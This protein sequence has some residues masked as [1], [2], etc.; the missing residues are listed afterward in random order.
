MNGLVIGFGTSG[1]A[2]ATLLVE[3][4]YRVTAVDANFEKLHVQKAVQE[5]I[6]K[7]VHFV[8]D[9]ISFP[10]IPFDLAVLSP[11]IPLTHPLCRECQTR[12][13]PLI[14]E[15]ELA[16]RKIH[17]PMIGITGTNGKTTVT[18]LISHL[19]NSFGY[20]SQPLGNSGTPLSTVTLRPTPL[21][22][23]SLELSSYQ[24]E[25]TKTP[26]LSSAIILNITPDHLDR[27][28]TMEKYAKAKMAIF[29][30]VKEGG[31]C[32]IHENCAREFRHLL[33]SR[34]IKLYGESSDCEL[35]RIGN[36]ILYRETVVFYLPKMY[37]QGFRHDI[38][39]IMAAY[40]LTRSYCTDNE[41]FKN[42]L[43]LFEKPPHRLQFV[44]TWRGI[45][46]INDSKGTNIDAVVRAV[47]SIQRPILLIAGGVDKQT[48]YAPWLEAFT[49]KVK[50][51]CV[52]GQAANNINRE[53]SG[54][55]PV[56]KYECLK[57]AV[58]GAIELANEGDVILLSPGCASTDMFKDYADRG[59]Q[60]ISFVNKL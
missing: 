54:R 9:L 2:A 32:W 29:D 57:S 55:Y 59:N 60:F 20:A 11:G 24:L 52:I 27:Y 13:I 39:N 28:G 3:E 16:S 38:E 7:G 4:G 5:L 6:D 43:E 23:I 53:L 33:P 10:P 49:G 26:C 25:T 40:A 58:S 44:R 22:I 12:K 51:I 31:E 14:S 8:S 41:K 45:D 30:L 36:K 21:D 18:Y 42:A 35:R 1:Q 48:G 19:L 47:E 46:F 56:N 15:I 34:E 37:E 50:G 17:L